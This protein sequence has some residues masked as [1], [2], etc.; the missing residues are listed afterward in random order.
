MGLELV[1]YPSTQVLYPLNKK[2]NHNKDSPSHNHKSNKDELLLEVT[3]F[4][5]RTKRVSQPI[6]DYPILARPIRCQE[7]VDISNNRKL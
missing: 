3:V 6:T 2:Q 7:T 5:G 1:N 4:A